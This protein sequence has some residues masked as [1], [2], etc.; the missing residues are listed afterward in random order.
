MF[1]QR[2]SVSFRFLLTGALVSIFI[3]TFLLFGP[4]ES[5]DIA[6]KYVLKTPFRPD[7]H[8]PCPSLIQPPSRNR[9]SWEFVVVRDG[10]NHGLSEDQCRRAFPKL[11][12]E[13]DKSALLR[14][15]KRV[16]FKE[17][18]S[19]TVDDGMVR[20]IIDQGEVCVRIE[21]QVGLDC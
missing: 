20:G 19:R 10:N 11:F 12:V 3:L 18:D 15:D 7:S 21:M 14:R 6:I 2:G 16:S 1:A 5:R 17:L 9:T 13:V 8:T 4:R